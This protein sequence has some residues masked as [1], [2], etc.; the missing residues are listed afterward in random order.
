MRLIW[1]EKPRYAPAALWPIDDSPATNAAAGSGSEDVVPNSRGSPSSGSAV[2]DRSFA[3]AKLGL[4]PLRFGPDDDRP[5]RDVLAAS[6][7]MPSRTTSRLARL[8]CLRLQMP[9][10]TLGTALDVIQDDWL[11]RTKLELHLGEFGDE[12]F[13]PAIRDAGVSRNCLA[14]SGDGLEA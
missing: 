1:T 14:E 11:A 4:P 8:R 6:L 2:S 3:R 7:F 13:L 9:L 5:H 10:P 12:P